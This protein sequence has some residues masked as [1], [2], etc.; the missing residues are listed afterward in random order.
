LQLDEGILQ[1]DAGAG[2][3]ALRFGELI[4]ADEFSADQKRR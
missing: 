2:G 3:H 4:G 1:L